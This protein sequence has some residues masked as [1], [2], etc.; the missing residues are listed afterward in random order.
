VTDDQALAEREAEYRAHWDQLMA[1]GTQPPLHRQMGLRIR[2]LSPSVVL[3]MEISEDVRGY[4]FGSV[5]GGILATFADV[6]GAVTLW[7][8]FDKA[9]QIPVTTDLHVRYFRQPKGGPLLAEARL[10]HRSKRLLSNECAITDAEGRVLVRTTATYVIQP[11][12]T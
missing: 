10:V 6:A 7:D 12:R 4:A 8:A 9:T 2:Q 3:S 1:D 5:H 11:L